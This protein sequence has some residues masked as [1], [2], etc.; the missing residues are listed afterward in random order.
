MHSLRARL[1]RFCTARSTAQSKQGANQTPLLLGF[2][3]SIG[4]DFL[5][6]VLG[7][8][9]PPVYYV[10]AYIAKHPFALAAAPASRSILAFLERRKENGH[11]KQ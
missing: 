7:P 8:L 9:A 10:E 4:G 1:F 2:I 5:S 3:V 6:G 11:T